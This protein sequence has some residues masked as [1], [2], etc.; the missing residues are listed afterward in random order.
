MKENVRKYLGLKVRSL[1]EAEGMTQEDL[2]SVCDVSWRTISN[3]ERGT[4]VPDLGMIFAISQKF[5][6][7]LDEL[8]NN[9]VSNNKSTSRLEKENQIIEKIRKTD[10]NLLDY[11]DEQLKLLLKHFH[12]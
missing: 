9:K 12:S 11:I 2:A 5:N 8:L 7:S 4:V 3:L 10:D 6:I 1:R